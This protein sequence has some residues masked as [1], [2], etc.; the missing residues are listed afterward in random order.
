MQLLDS[1]TR[2]GAISRLLHWALAALILWQF[3]GMGLKLLF[4]RNGF[5]GFFVGTH[6]S[7]GFVIFLLV[8]LR[9]AWAILSRKR[10]PSHG[11]GALGKAAA[12]G[13]GVLYLLM[14]AIPT[15]ALL[16]AWGGTR[17]FAP[18]GTQIFAPREAELAWATA[19]GNLVHGEL[20]WVM[21]VVIAGHIAM[22]ALH[23]GLWRD[24]TLRR[25]A[26]RG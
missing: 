20:G 3:L 25:M 14:L 17:G 10:R 15:L 24:G 19:P 13:H 18:F 21:A 11:E 26:G 12:A 6:Q 7:V 4:G 16:R 22:V 1:E 9:V 23:E 8:V 2:Y 5:T